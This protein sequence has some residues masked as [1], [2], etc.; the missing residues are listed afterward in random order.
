[1]ADE[2]AASITRV[3][4]SNWRRLHDEDACH[5]GDSQ[6]RWQDVHFGRPHG[7]TAAQGPPRAALQSWARCVSLAQPSCSVG[8]CKSAPEQL[9]QTVT[10]TSMERKAVVAGNENWT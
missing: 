7:G 4:L 10:E 6:W 8:V 3:S 1:M 9:S 2:P 5:R